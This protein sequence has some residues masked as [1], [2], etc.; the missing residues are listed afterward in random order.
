MYLINTYIILIIRYQ[1]KDRTFIQNIYNE[2]AIWTYRIYLDNFSHSSYLIKKF[3]Q[4]NKIKIPIF[5]INSIM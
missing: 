3:K 4:K 2:K 1:K 5:Q